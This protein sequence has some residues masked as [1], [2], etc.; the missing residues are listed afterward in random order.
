MNQ[1][2][3]V[4]VFTTAKPCAAHAAAFEDMSEAARDHLA[5]LAHRL[6]ADA[7]SQPVAV[8][9]DSGAR[10]IRHANVDIRCLGEAQRS[11]SFMDRRLAL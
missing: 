1:V 5:A 4:D 9:I 6:P 3:L 2:S 8:C 7:R 10:L 11:A